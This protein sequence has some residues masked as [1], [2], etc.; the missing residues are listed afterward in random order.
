MATEAFNYTTHP[1]GYF[2]A[3]HW[4]GSIES[5][6]ALARFVNDDELYGQCGFFAIETE[7]GDTIIVHHGDFVIPGYD[8]RFSVMD[9]DAFDDYFTKL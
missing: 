2:R 1:E 3:F 9:A 7:D 4:D 5:T 6:N 8:G